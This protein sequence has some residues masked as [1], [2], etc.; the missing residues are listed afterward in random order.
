MSPKLGKFF[1]LRAFITEIMIGCEIFEIFCGRGLARAASTV[2]IKGKRVDNWRESTV[3][4][5]KGEKRRPKLFML[6]KCPKL[7]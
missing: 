3:H 7:F 5:F 4:Y 1:Q 6:H 2:L